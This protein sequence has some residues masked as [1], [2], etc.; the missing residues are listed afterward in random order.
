V[1]AS[2]GYTISDLPHAVTWG[3][4]TA[5]ASFFPVVG[6]ALIW[7][8]VSLY[9]ISRGLISHAVL[10]AIW[11][12]LLVVGIGEYMLRPRLVGRKGKGHP[13]LMLVAALGGIQVFG[14]AGIVV[15]PVT[16]SLFLA[17]LTIY[18]REIDAT[19]RSDTQRTIPPLPAISEPDSELVRPKAMNPAVFV[20]N[21]NGEVTVLRSHDS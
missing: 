10:Q 18:E 2:I 20:T 7:V 15:G 8:P 3:L 1:V 12:L 16:M 5:V 19:D 9:F 21:E 13:L 4:F 11:G 6:T 14:L 17:I